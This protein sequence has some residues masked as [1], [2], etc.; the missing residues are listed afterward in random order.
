MQHK[1]ASRSSPCLTGPFRADSRWGKFTQ[2]EPWAMLYW[3]L[4]AKD[5]PSGNLKMSKPQGPIAMTRDCFQAA[6]NHAKHILPKS[7]INRPKSYLSSRHSTQNP[8]VQEMLV[9]ARDREG[10]M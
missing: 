3:P 7:K 8:Y 4:R 1:V 6:K 5:L 9:Q 2:G 10:S